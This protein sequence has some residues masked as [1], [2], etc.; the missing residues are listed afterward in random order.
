MKHSKFEI[1]MLAIILMCNE[2]IEYGMKYPNSDIGKLMGC[3]YD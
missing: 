3:N 2:M 1:M